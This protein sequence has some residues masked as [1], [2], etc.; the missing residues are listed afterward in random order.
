MK[1]DFFDLRLSLQEQPTDHETSSNKFTVRYILKDSF[2]FKR[3]FNAVI[4]RNLTRIFFGG[5]FFK[6]LILLSRTSEDAYF[7]IPL[8]AISKILAFILK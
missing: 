2:M 1:I 3:P 8:F 7:Q 6:V 5:D 4:D